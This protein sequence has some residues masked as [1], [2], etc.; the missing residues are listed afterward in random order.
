[1]TS[2]QTFHKIKDL[3]D[4][5]KKTKQKIYQEQVD[6][7][8]TVATQLFE[9]LK[10]KEK[11]EEKFQEELKKATVQAQSFILHEQYIEQLDYNINLLQP[12]VQQARSEMEK[13]HQNFSSAYIE[14]KKY[15]K[16]IENK[17]VKR[18]LWMKSE[19]N[20]SMDELS[21]RQYLNYKNR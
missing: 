12:K 14:V 18:E 16:L 7:F 4:R 3:Q 11:A 17:R 6:Q 8:E 21:T 9:V 2:L 15:E 19:E 5:E 13:A 20:K 10:E 1:M